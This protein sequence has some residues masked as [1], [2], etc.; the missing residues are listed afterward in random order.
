MKPRVEDKF[1]SR[2]H[3]VCMSDQR[4]KEKISREDA[5]L[6]VTGPWPFFLQGGSNTLSSPL[7]VADTLVLL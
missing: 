2:L 4:E 5:D 1:S 7:G 6:I 3:E